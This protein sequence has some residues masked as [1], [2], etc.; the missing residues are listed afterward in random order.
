MNNLKTSTQTDVAIKNFRNKVVELENKL[1]NSN[2]TNIVKGNS[3]S[4]PL[5]HSFSDGVYVREMKWVK[6]V[7]L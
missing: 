1:L 2:D 6:E 4:F 5:T 3:D 7:W